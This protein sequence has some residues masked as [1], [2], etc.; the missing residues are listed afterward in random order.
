LGS[1]K[2]S[3]LTFRHASNRQ[4]FEGVG[5]GARRGCI[6]GERF[7]TLPASAGLPAL[8][9]FFNAAEKAQ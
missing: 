3:A 4:I 6:F 7:R 9:G 2:D 5:R 1:W 8:A